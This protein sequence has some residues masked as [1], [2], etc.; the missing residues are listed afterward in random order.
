MYALTVGGLR[1]IDRKIYKEW[2]L[3]G[4]M[5]DWLVM[6]FVDEGKLSGKKVESRL[7]VTTI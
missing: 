5:V 4:R 6:E 2:K 7:E 3:C 1:M